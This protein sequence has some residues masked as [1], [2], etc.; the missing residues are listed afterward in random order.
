E[1][2]S[3][4]IFIRNGNFH[5]FQ[6]YFPQKYKFEGGRVGSYCTWILLL[7]FAAVCF[8]NCWGIRK[9][10]VYKLRARNERSIN[11]AQ[12]A[13]GPLER[14]MEAARRMQPD[15]T[16]TLAG[17]TDPEIDDDDGAP[18][19]SADGPP[20]KRKKTER[21][22]QAQLLLKQAAPPHM[23]EQNILQATSL[24]RPPCVIKRPKVAGKTEKACL[25]RPKAP[26]LTLLELFPLQSADPD[27]NGRSAQAR[28]HLK[29][30]AAEAQLQTAEKTEQIMWLFGKPVPLMQASTDAGPPPRPP[31]PSTD[32][33]LS[34]YEPDDVASDNSPATKLNLAA[35]PALLK[36][37]A[38]NASVSLP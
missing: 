24:P 21:S 20:Q 28:S 7:E 9:K 3:V 30:E 5:K 4:F 26:V 19:Q 34:C 17:P 1:I 8:L 25:P 13:K 23:Q 38:A 22:G 2:Q 35:D 10:R 33:R 15:Q 32:L 37:K 16:E 29:A 31:G 18:A 12:M 14:L 11:E 27:D 6:R 36:R